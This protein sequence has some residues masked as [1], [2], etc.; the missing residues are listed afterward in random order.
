MI[1]LF[2]CSQERILEDPERPYLLVLG[3]AQDAGYPQAGCQKDCCKA[4]WK[5]IREKKYVASLALIDPKSEHYWL[6]DA[7]P[8]LK[9]QLQI[10]NKHLRPDKFILPS[11]VFLTHAHIGHYTGLMEFGKEVMDAKSV[12]IYAYPRMKEFLES[13]GPWSQ[14]VK[15]NNID[16]N[17]LNHSTAVELKNGITVEPFLVPHRQEYSETAGYFISG[18]KTKAMFIPDIDSWDKWGK[19]IRSVILNE[20]DLAFLDA[21]FYSGD[22]LPNRDIKE[23]PHP[24]VKNTMEM[25][26]EKDLRKKIHFIHMNHTNPLL[27][28]LNKEYEYVKNKGFGI[29]KLEE[30]H[31]LK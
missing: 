17:L 19:D 8:D 28:P 12:P 4:Y 26:P 3:N 10:V 30:K 18:G 2:S 11:G 5:G 15:R 21:T 27:D 7:T 1:F 23:V 22:E 29:A 13:S 14:L 20:V 16:I 24:L 31:I 6:F 25:F 9:E